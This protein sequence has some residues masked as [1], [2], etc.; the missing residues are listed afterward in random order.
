M[1]GINQLVLPPPPRWGES[2]AAGLAAEQK[3][4]TVSGVS[5]GVSVSTGLLTLVVIGGIAY[6][7]LK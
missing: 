4:S 7:I 5:A 6:L 3:Q 2:S 1:F